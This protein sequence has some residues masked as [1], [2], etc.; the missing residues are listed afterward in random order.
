MITETKPLAEV[1][2]EAI[3]LLYRELG[4]VN[5]VRFLKQFTVGFGDYTQERDLLFDNKALDDI[6]KEIEQRQKPS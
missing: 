4:V 2:L 6:V 5:A 1:N 3:R